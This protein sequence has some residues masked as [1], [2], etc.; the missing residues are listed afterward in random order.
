MW[1]FTEMMVSRSTVGHE[2]SCPYNGDTPFESHSVGKTSKDWR[3]A[4]LKME[5]S[6]VYLSRQFL[7][8][9]C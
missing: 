1:L 8:F 2:M 7:S 9:G 3:A 5:F 6:I 4:R